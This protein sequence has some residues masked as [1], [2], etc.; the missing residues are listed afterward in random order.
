MARK[1]TTREMSD[2]HERFLADLLDGQMSKGSGNQFN[3]PMDG[4]NNRNQ[5]HALAWDGKSTFAGSVAVS[6]EMWA[7]AVVQSHD[8]IPMLAL[9]FYNNYTLEP[10]RDL[11][12]LDAHDF[13]E[14]LADARQYQEGQAEARAEGW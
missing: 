14:I 4:R 2:R 12:V 7:K 11:V 9:R 6:R 13:A 8:Q 3:N 1:P 5:A 10:V